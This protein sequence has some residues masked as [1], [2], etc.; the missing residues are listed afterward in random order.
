M[1]APLVAWL[2]RSVIL[3]LIAKAYGCHQHVA[4][5]MLWKAQAKD[6]PALP[7]PIPYQYY[8]EHGK[9]H[10]GKVAYQ[11]LWFGRSGPKIDQAYYVPSAKIPP[12]ATPLSPQRRTIRYRFELHD[13]YSSDGAGKVADQ[14]HAR[15]M[16]AQHAR[17]VHTEKVEVLI[18]LAVKLRLDAAIAAFPLVAAF[19]PEADKRTAPRVTAA[20]WLPKAIAQMKQDGM[21]PL[22]IGI[23]AFARML[24]ARAKAGG[25]PWKW[26]HLANQLRE[27]E[28]WPLK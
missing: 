6:D 17:A 25:L 3:E 2:L 28:L 24:E 5:Q 26:A 9:L 12:S 18:C 13:D 22:G 8:D 15:L 11:R 23:E 19:L 10:E 1:A 20:S 4:E 14:K 7:D 16:H 21:I 27:H